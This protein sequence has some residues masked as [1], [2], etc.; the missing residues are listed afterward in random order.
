MGH[1]QTEQAV[2][3]MYRRLGTKSPDNYGILK[4]NYKLNM[5]IASMMFDEDDYDY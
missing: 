5:E 4:S 3:N 2:V 1:E